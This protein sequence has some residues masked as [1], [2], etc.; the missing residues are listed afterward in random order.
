MQANT[1]VIPLDAKPS[2]PTSQRPKYAK[3]LNNEDEALTVLRLAMY[4]YDTTKLAKT[5][6][7]SAG[8]IYAI[9][10]G[11]TKWPRPNTFFGLLR[12]LDLEM[13]LIPRG[14]NEGR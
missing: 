13:H 4:T 8:C 1:N 12:A 9:Q 3:R 7:V 6:G 11:R 10:S 14:K 5:V 2:K